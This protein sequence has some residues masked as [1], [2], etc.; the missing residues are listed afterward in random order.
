MDIIK[1]RKFLKSEDYTHFECSYSGE[2]RVDFMIQ[3]NIENLVEVVTY[4]RINSSIALKRLYVCHAGNFHG[5][6][7]SYLKAAFLAGQFFGIYVHYGT[8]SFI[9]PKGKCI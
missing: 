6:L 8:K 9:L 1:F 7:N 5:M 3:T 4:Q 2:D